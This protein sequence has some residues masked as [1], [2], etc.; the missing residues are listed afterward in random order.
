MEHIVNYVRAKQFVY[1]KENFGIH[2]IKTDY[3]V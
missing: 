1:I 2:K 3:T